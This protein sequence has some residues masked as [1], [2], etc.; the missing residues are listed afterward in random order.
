M[1]RKSC[2]ALTGFNKV[3]SEQPQP[4]AT[5][6]KLIVSKTL[7]LCWWDCIFDQIFA[8]CAPPRREKFSDLS[9]NLIST[10]SWPHYYAWQ[11]WNWLLQKPW[12]YGGETAFSPKFLQVVAPQ[13]VKNF[14]IYLKTNRALAQNPKSVYLKSGIDCLKILA[15]IAVRP[16]RTDDGRTT[17]GRR[18]TDRRR[19]WW[20]YPRGPEG[21]EGKND[22]SLWLNAWSNPMFWKNNKTPLS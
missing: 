8:S 3:F 14:Q 12:R 7:T 20:Q 17:D 11:V 16:I 22:N 5:S 19:K 13:R 1:K 18:T 15:F 10:G 9:Q 21:A 6:V 2:K 4:S